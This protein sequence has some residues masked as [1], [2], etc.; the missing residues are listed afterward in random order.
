MTLTV[1]V[2]MTS[3]TWMIAEVVMIINCSPLNGSF[4][5]STIGIQRY[6]TL[7]VIPQVLVANGLATNTA[8][9]V[10]TSPHSISEVRQIVEVVMTLL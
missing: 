9:A 4:V 6:T 8:I 3:T 7:S 5:T 10:N 1:L 2:A